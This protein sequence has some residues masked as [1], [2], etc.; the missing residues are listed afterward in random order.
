MGGVF[1]EVIPGWRSHC[2]YWQEKGRREES[3]EPRITVS[4][5]RRRDLEIERGQ[6]KACERFFDQ[7]SWASE[8]LY[9]YIGFKMLLIFWLENVK[10]RHLLDIC[11]VEFTK[12]FFSS[13]YGWNLL[14]KCKLCNAVASY[15]C[16]LLWKNTGL[17]VRGKTRVWVSA[18]P[19][20]LSQVKNE[21]IMYRG[22]NEKVNNNE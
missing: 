18:Q 9:V 21:L 22:A 15:D 7:E 2:K 19:P 13:C 16:L 1:E 11:W 6:H 17:G 20:T 5:R 12:R 14:S 10:P 4:K 8:E 3:W